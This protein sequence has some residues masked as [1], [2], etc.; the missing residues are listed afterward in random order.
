M[1]TSYDMCVDYDILCSI[2][3]KLQKIEYDLNNSMDHMVK[4]I[5]SSQ[6]FLVGIQF[7]K[8]KRT[9]ASCMEI[10]RKTGNNIRH[11]MEY[12]AKLKD[13]LEEYGKYSYNG[14]AL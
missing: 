12:I 8:A 7:E 4:A 5:Q 1:A 10:T 2:E 9:T 13:A 6:D 14:E 3:D 11:A